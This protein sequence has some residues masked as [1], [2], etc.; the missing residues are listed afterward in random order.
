MGKR[1]LFVTAL[2]AVVLLSSVACGGRERWITYT[3]EA[4]GITFDTP[5]TWVVSDNMDAANSAGVVL[6]VADSAESL[7]AAQFDGVGGTILI[8]N[9]AEFSGQSDPLLLL[10]FFTGLFTAGDDVALVEVQPPI[11]LIINEQ[12]AASATYTG[13]FDGQP[14]T[15]QFTTIVDASQ[16]AVLIMIDATNGEFTEQLARLQ[17]SVKLDG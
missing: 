1:L 14:G 5:E 3:N 8:A 15:Y 6:T 2:V 16:I 10:D 4:A 13:E 9:S 7:G 11:S 12:T 17:Q